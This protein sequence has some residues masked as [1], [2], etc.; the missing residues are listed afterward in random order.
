MFFLIYT[1]HIGIHIAW[2]HNYL[3]RILLAICLWNYVDPTTLFP[4]KLWHKNQV[5]VDQI[6][7]E[8]TSTRLS[9][10]ISYL[11]TLPPDPTKQTMR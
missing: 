4:R 9:Y 7:E 8:V 10:G 6:I 11:V 5:K 2:H 3:Y 1:N